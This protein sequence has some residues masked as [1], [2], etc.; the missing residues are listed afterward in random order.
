M[1]AV[2]VAW[3]LF[4]NKIVWWELFVPTLASFLFILISYYTMKS[5]TLHDVEYNGYIITEAKYYESWETWVSKTCS[6]RYACGTYT[7]GSGKNKTTHTKYCTRYYDCSYCDYNSERYVMIDTKGNEISISA[8][9]Y[10]SLMKQWKAKPKFVELNRDID[11]RGNC[12]K[13]GDMYS[14]EWNKD[15]LTSETTTYTKSFSNILKSN[16]SA[17]NFPTIEED[18]AKKIGLYDYPKIQNYNFQTSVIGIEKSNL[19]DKGKIIKTLDF[20]NGAF[21]SQYK[22]KIFTLFFKEKEI[23]TAFLQEAYWDG[24]N[25]NEIIVCIG[26]DKKGNIEWVKPFSWCDNKRVVID[27]RED[28]MSSK[29]ID[30]NTFY[31]VYINAI[32]TNWKYKSFEDFN[33]LSFEPTT[34]QLI[35]VYIFT[36]FISI[37]IVWWCVINDEKH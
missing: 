12:G 33:Y 35:F 32:R 17:F 3:V 37:G 13:D 31:N 7:T 10:Y 24:G 25:Q 4:K 6:E 21:G 5:Y 29:N 36:L 27:I 20:I 26:L 30:S 14:I 8:E 19:K 18:E 34:G 23:N 9:K 15:P 1:L 28:L 2:F 11:Y 16:H 22:V